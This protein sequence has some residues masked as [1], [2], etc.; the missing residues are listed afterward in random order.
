MH[1][2]RHE[3]EEEDNTAKNVHDSVEGWDKGRANETRGNSPVKSDGNQ[4]V[5]VVRSEYLVNRNAVWRNPAG[6][7]EVGQAFEN[8]SR[9]PIVDKRCAANDEE[10]SVATHGPAICL[11]RVG[12][13]VVMQS[14]EQGT[15]HEIRWPDHSCGPNEK[16]SSQTSHAVSS[17][18]CGDSEKKLESSSKILLIE[19]LLRQENIRGIK[20]ATAVGRLDEQG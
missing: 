18:Q 14:V 4:A 11:G 2:H 16:A 10:E 19:D 5:S 1:T 13:R 9:E 20:G 6:D 8:P 17:T 7:S 3:H 15:I 12:S